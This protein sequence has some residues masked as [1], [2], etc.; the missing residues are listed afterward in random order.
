[1][2]YNLAAGYHLLR[3]QSIQFIA[4]SDSQLLKYETRRPKD[5]VCGRQRI[6]LLS[7]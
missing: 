2:I 4:I 6:D 5:L 3:V 7:H 1:M